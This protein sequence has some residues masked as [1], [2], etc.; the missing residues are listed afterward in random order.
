MKIC[1]GALVI[2]TVCDIEARTN[3]VV[4]IMEIHI[5]MATQFMIKM[6]LPFSE[7]KAS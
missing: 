2:K 6:T 4:T 5:H 7:E 3:K 1:A